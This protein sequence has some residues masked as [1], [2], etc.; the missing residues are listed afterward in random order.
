MTLPPPPTGSPRI[1]TGIKG[2]DTILGGGFMRGGIYIVRGDPGAGKTILTNQICFNFI[3]QAPDR[4]CL[5]V[6]LLAENHAR[7]LGN[8]RGLSFF[9]EARIPDGLTYLSA[10]GEL[11]DGG[12]KTLLDLLRREIQ[13]RRCAI[14]VLDGLVS[15][16]AMAASEVAFKDFVHGLQEIAL[17][18]ECTMFLTN[19][20]AGGVSPEQ[21]MVDGL[22]ELSDRV[23]GWRAESDLQVKKF[24]GGAYLRGRHGY[25]ITDDGVVVHPRIEALLA[26]PSRPDE[27]DIDLRIGSGNLALDAL[28]GEDCPP[29]RRRWSLAPQAPERPQSGWNS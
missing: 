27:A 5:F 16:Q 25:K 14:L 9:D 20:I 26:M 28:L 23:Y 29:R 13:R 15:V 18:T 19:N 4:R 22:I 6:T 21:T 24:R 1:P 3:A 8:L 12:L 17:G 2:L 11:R 10:L 7:M